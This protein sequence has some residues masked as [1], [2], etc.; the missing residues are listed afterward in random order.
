MATAGELENYGNHIQP[1]VEPGV[2]DIDPS[3]RMKDVF[4]R[5]TQKEQE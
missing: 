5:V 2:T 3:A 1:V 4:D